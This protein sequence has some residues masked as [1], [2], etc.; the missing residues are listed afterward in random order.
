[1]DDPVVYNHL[2]LSRALDQEE[3]FDVL[4]HPSVIIRSKL[5]TFRSANPRVLA[6]IWSPLFGLRVPRVTREPVDGIVQMIPVM[7]DAIHD[8]SDIALTVYWGQA[9]A[10]VSVDTVDKNS[11]LR[12]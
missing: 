4:C 2:T 6:E 5:S 3:I 8:K 12:S 11:G 7:S 10:L 9:N 1:M